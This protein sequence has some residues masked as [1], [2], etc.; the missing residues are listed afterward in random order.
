MMATVLLLQ[1]FGC[2]QNFHEDIYL[3][4]ILAMSVLISFYFLTFI[5]NTVAMIIPSTWC[6]QASGGPAGAA[7][8]HLP[9]A[10]PQ[11]GGPDGGGSPRREAGTAGDTQRAC[12]S[13]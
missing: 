11:R 5:A 1:I 12:C 4:V 9:A 10:V 3:N 13:L 8:E 7:G 2:M 6:A